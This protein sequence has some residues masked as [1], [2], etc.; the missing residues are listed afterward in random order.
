ML[1]LVMHLCCFFKAILDI[2]TAF[3][4]VNHNKLIEAL[5][6]AGVPSLIT[7]VINDWNDKLFVSVRWRGGLFHQFKIVCGVR[8]GSLLSPLTHSSMYF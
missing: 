7:R 6:S 8:Q 3:D 2:S 1:T 5:I 4:T